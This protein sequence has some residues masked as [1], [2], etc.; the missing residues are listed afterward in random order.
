MDRVLPGTVAA[1]PPLGPAAQIFPGEVQGLEDSLDGLDIVLG[2]MG[3]RGDRQTQGRGDF[4]GIFL[5]DVP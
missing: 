3:G 4:V 1:C 5:R 2:A